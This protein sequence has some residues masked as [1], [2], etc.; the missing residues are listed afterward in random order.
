[1]GSWSNAP[2]KM[3]IQNQTNE[4]VFFADNSGS[5]KG[6][7]LVAGESIVIDCK[8]TSGNVSNTFHANTNFYVT[9]TAGTGDFKVASLYAF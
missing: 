6:I 7:T 2:V 4:T 9:A 1:L 8:L 5:T 3:F